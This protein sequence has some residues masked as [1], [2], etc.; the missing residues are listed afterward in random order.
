VPPT[1]PSVADSTWSKVLHALQAL[2]SK[3]AASAAAAAVSGAVLA[4]A[5]ASRHPDRVLLWF[6]GSAS[7]ITLVMVFV[8]QHTQTR[9]QVALQRKLD[10]VLHALPNADDRLISLESGSGHDMAAAEQRHSAL[11]EQ[12]HS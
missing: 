11:R 3:A 9:Q 1:P 10:E 6:E 12:A 7:A 8:L 5:I 2:S 4:W